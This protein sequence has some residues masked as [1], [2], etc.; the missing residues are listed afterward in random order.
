M[1]EIESKLDSKLVKGKCVNYTIF[2][3]LA[4]LILTYEYG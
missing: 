3:L 1:E 4:I 2:E